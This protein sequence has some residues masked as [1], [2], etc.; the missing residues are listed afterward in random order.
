LAQPPYP[1]AK[2]LLR[3]THG[4]LPPHRHLLH[5]LHAP[6]LHSPHNLPQKHL[7]HNPV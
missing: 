2:A 7:P 3:R 4:H 1:P 5:N 6:P